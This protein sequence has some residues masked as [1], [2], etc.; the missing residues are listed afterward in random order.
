MDRQFGDPSTTEEDRG[1]GVIVAQLYRASL[2]E[3]GPLIKQIQLPI[4]QKGLQTCHPGASSRD[5]FFLF[6][7]E[8]VVH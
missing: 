8:V 5:E 3:L 1:Q 6:L 2:S 4:L 7:W